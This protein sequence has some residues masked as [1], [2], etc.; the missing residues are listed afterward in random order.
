MSSEALWRLDMFTK[1]FPVYF[2]GASS[3]DPYEYLDNCHEVLQNMGI[4][5]TNG[6]DFAASGN[7]QHQGSLAMVPAP[8]ASPPAQPARGRGQA[9][10]GG[11]QDIRVYSRDASVLFDLGSTHSYVSS[12]FASYLVVPHDSLS[13]PVYVSTLVGDAIVLDRVYHLR[14][15]TVGSL[16]TSVDLLLLDMVDFDVILCMD[17]LSPYHAI[18]Y[19]HA[20]TVTLALPGLPLFEW[21]GT[22]GHSTSRVIFYMKARCMVENGCLA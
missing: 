11:G 3:E 16:E 9:A 6:V 21:R 5:E 4:M 1:L 19:C 17:W 10:R 22:P 20:K 18:L 2:S 12:Y 15:V 8:G 14:V 13:A 7:S